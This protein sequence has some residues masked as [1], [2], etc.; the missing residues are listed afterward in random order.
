MEFFWRPDQLAFAGGILT[1][2]VTALL[3]QTAF[4]TLRLMSSLLAGYVLPRFTATDVLRY[5]K[6]AGKAET[7]AAR[8]CR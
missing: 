6:W 8:M 2:L 3:A 4:N 7:A 1:A 5:G